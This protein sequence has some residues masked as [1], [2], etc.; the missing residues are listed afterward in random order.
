LVKVRAHVLSDASK[1]IS[2]KLAN[3][4]LAPFRIVAKTGDVNF[5]LKSLTDPLLTR[6]YNVVDMEPYFDPETMDRYG[7]PDAVPP[8]AP[9]DP[10]ADAP[11]ER[12]DSPVP[13]ED[14]P[15]ESSPPTSES[16]VETHNSSEDDSPTAD[17]RP[18]RVI[19]PPLRYRVQRFGPA[20]FATLPMTGVPNVDWPAVSN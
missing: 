20:V 3:I 13:S 16:E 12:A 19:R 1:N 9:T 14:P 17:G 2:S 11:H 10:A 6:V 15:E 7:L 18:R 8:P 4:Y 5:R